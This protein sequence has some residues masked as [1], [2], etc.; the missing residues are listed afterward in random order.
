[1]NNDDDLKVSPSLC[2]VITNQTEH[3][4]NTLVSR[5]VRVCIA[6]CWIICITTT[7]I[8]IRPIL[9]FSINI[10]VPNSFESNRYT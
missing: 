10:F 8:K 7:L 3:T 5:A 6:I 9:N 4:N 2:G 1:M